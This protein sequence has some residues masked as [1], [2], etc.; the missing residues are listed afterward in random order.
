MLL[1]RPTASAAS[2]TPGPIN[3][4]KIGLDL[5]VATSGTYENG[6]HVLNP[7]TGLPADELISVTVVGADILEADIYATAV[8]AMGTRGLQFMEQVPGYEA[9][10]I[11]ADLLAGRTS[12]LDLIRDEVA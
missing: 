11:G 7:R 8:L 1:F 9:S 6:L 3:L 4:L 2:I 5:A 10:V 12:G